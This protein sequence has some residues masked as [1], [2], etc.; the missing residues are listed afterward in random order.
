MAWFWSEH[1]RVACGVYRVRLIENQEDNGLRKVV[2]DDFCLVFELWKSTK[3]KVEN[4][5]AINLNVVACD[6]QQTHDN[7][8]FLERNISKTSLDEKSPTI[9]AGPASR[10]LALIR[11][12]ITLIHTRSCQ[13]IYKDILRTIYK[14]MY[15]IYIYFAAG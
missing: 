1:L 8:L 7:F 6:S 5:L 4:K 3:L 13:Q 12:A 14:K 11:N 15:V 10:Y 9:I 2:R